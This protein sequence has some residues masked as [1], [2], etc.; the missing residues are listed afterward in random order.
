MAV[1]SIL[2]MV[3]SPVQV[4]VL[5][6]L[7]LNLRLTVAYDRLYESWLTTSVPVKLVF[8]LGSIPPLRWA[9]P[10]KFTTSPLRSSITIVKLAFLSIFTVAFTSSPVIS[11]CFNESSC[12]ASNIE[13]IAGALRSINSTTPFLSSTPGSV[14]GSTKTMSVFSFTVK[15]ASTIGLAISPRTF[16]LAS[17]NN[18][19]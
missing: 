14:V 2:A 9:S 19:P 10:F 1:R 11:D 6:C 13:S 8:P 5:P 16:T 17:I 15:F 3:G 18:L 12:R 4:M 7:K